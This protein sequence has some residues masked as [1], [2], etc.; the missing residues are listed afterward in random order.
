MP[1]SFSYLPPLITGFVGLVIGVIIEPI[2]ALIWGA[3]IRVTFVNGD[4]AY[5]SDGHD[6]THSPIRTVRISAMAKRGL[7]HLTDCQAFVVSI[8]S[9]G[10]NRWRPTAFIDPLRLPWSAT[11]NDDPH[12]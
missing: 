5:V 8:D 9:W 11:A 4:R 3:R 7:T 10:D 12:R 1:A 2:K 6:Q